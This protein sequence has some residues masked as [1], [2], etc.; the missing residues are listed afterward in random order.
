M[1]LLKPLLEVFRY[2][3]TFSGSLKF[4]FAC[5]PFSFLN[6]L[7]FCSFVVLLFPHPI[8]C[9]IWWVLD[10]IFVWILSQKT[11]EFRMVVALMGRLRR[12]PPKFEILLFSFRPKNGNSLGVEHSYSIGK[13]VKI[14]IWWMVQNFRFLLC[15]EWKNI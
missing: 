6:I 10:C 1:H 3:S 5:Q 14:E 8:L 13:Y 2:R 4:A 9:P 12:R 15:L 11:A 7:V